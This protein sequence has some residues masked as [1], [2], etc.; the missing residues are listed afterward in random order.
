MALTALLQERAKSDS[1]FAE[2]LKKPNKSIKE[3]VQYI[4]G[5]LC[6]VAKQERTG[7][8]AVLGVCDS[9]VLDMAVHYYDED[10]IKIK[11]IQ[12]KAEVKTAV[13]KT[14][15]KKETKTE[16]KK[17]EKKPVKKNPLLESLKKPAPKKEDKPKLTDIKPKS[18][19]SKKETEKEKPNDFVGSLFDF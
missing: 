1:L 2:T 9:D 12:K 19:D 15:G 16:E 10:D 11:P 6:D 13:A 3:C 5:E 18:Q 4:Y 17:E 7:N 14:G 8:T